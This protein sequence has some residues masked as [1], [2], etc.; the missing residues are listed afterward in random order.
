MI[1]RTLRE[2]GGFIRQARENAGLT[3]SDLAAKLNARR[4]RVIYL[5]RGE[6]Q[7]STAFLLDVLKVLDLG[8]EINEGGRP[9][10]A[11]SSK[12]GG[13]KTVPYSIDDIA[14]GHIKRT[15]G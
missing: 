10:P 13:S 5:E 2:L 11:F 8:F 4:Q 1:V 6:G 12:R 3:Q 14:D 9:R 15:K 7:I